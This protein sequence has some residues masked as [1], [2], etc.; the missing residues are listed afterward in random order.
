MDPI[1]QPSEPARAVRPYRA[2]RISDAVIHVL[3]L[4]AALVATP[5]LI[6]V[7]AFTR[8]AAAVA[9]TAIYS[10][11]L[12]LMI[13]ASALYHLVPLEGW[14]RTLKRI[15]H[16]AIYVKIAGTYTAFVVLSAQGWGVLL[17]IWTAALA[18]T[19]L[20]M[21]APDRFRL[22][23]L[24][25]YLGMGWGG[26]ALG[27][28]LIGA[29][30]APVIVLMLVGGLLYSVGVIFFLWE[31]LPFQTAIWHF[32]VLAASFVF[33]AAVMVQLLTPMA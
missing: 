27:G 22:A 2:E 25:L 15:D 4:T 28:T 8:D 32:F 5:V 16:S 17:G 26:V 33:Y 31:R 7:A 19:S 9:G 1:L 23:A 18:G 30:S 24:A 21:W 12:I 3:G 29:L 13:L 10:G 20:K 11:T 6:T 14:K